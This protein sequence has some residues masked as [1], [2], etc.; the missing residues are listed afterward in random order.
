M[1]NLKLSKLAENEI[2]KQD[3]QKIHGGNEDELEVDP[4]MTECRNACAEQSNRV[5]R[6]VR[7]VAQ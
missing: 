4:G 5:K 1:K 2:A 7:R 6:Q 3:L